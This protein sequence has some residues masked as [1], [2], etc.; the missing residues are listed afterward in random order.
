MLSMENALKSFEDELDR[1]EFRDL[2]HASDRA[3]R[4]LGERVF[5]QAMIYA[6]MKDN[7]N[8]SEPRP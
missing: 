1:N 5:V 3:G 8:P 7:A 4:L 2:R 6:G